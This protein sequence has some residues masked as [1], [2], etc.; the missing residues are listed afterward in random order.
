MTHRQLP[1]KIKLTNRGSPGRNRGGREI[2]TRGYQNGYNAA[3]AEIYKALDDLDHAHH[4]AGCRPCEVMKS[5]VEWTMQG[6]GPLLTEEEF[7]T[8]AGIMAAGPGQGTGEDGGVGAAEPDSSGGVTGHA[9]AG[10]DLTHWRRA[11]GVRASMSTKRKKKDR[12][13][14][15]TVHCPRQDRLAGEI[16]TAGIVSDWWLPRGLVP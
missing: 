11:K 3:Y 12:G 8:M 10:A 4:C 7:N 15:M 14:S 9:S 6:L 5:V 16:I 1:L 13:R 2:V